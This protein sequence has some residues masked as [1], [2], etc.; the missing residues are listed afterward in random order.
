MAYFLYENLVGSSKEI[1][2]IVERLPGGGQSAEGEAFFPIRSGVEK[3]LIYWRKRRRK[4]GRM[5][6][7]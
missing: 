5:L 6:V 1:D 3:M 7:S 4:W 2:P